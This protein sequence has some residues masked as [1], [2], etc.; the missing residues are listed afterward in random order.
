[1]WWAGLEWREVGAGQG[2]VGWGGATWVR[3]SVRAST[4]SAGRAGITEEEEEE[5]EGIWEICR[6]S[7]N[8]CVVR[9]CRG[10]CATAGR[11]GD[12]TRA[13]CDPRACTGPGLVERAEEDPIAEDPIFLI[14]S[15]DMVRR[16][17]AIFG[18]RAVA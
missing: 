9:T 11:A 14:R 17:V 4:A 10:G 5:E 2:W 18:R 8:T 3:A 13:G 15:K 6:A 1:M 16:R 7:R 12:A